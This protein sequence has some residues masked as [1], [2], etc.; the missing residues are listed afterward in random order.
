MIAEKCKIFF[1]FRML[2]QVRGHR[3]PVTAPCWRLWPQ[4]V[5]WLA[6]TWKLN[7]RIHGSAGFHL[8]FQDCTHRA[9]LG[10]VW[11]GIQQDLV[12][13][14]S[15]LD[16]TVQNWL[17]WPEQPSLNHAAWW[18]CNMKSCNKFIRQSNSS[19]A[20]LAVSSGQSCAHHSLLAVN[21]SSNVRWLE[22]WPQVAPAIHL[23][24][25]KH[26]LVAAD[27]MV[28]HTWCI[29]WSYGSEI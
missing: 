29:S 17:P 6:S 10:N 23:M 7:L 20:A 3:G 11:K 12:T 13:L 19:L 22:G 28:Q 27:T 8:H 15:G 26:Y 2:F 4:V 5:I 14:E 18:S 25:V 1:S 21:F 16:K 9:K 24:T